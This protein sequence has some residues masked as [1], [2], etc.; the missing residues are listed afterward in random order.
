MAHDA[1][2]TAE[3]YADCNCTVVLA[4]CAVCSQF[5]GE[6]TCAHAAEA[7]ATILADIMYLLPNCFDEAEREAVASAADLSCRLK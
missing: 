6:S 1:C 5:G 2:V 3:G 4:K 7:A